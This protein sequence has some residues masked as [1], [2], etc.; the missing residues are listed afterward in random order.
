M[1]SSIISIFATGLLVF[2]SLVSVAFWIPKLINKKRLKEILGPKY[3][4]VLL[5]YLANG[6]FLL[7]LGGLLLYLNKQ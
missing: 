1:Q 6:P 3:S 2:G 5:I 7:I 4:L